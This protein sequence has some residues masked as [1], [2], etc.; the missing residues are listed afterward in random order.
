MRIRR[1]D[2]AKARDR[3]CE[4]AASAKTVEATVAAVDGRTILP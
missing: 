4:V 2:K 1:R 3:R